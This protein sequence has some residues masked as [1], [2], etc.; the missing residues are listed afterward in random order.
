MEPHQQKKIILRQGKLL[1]FTPNDLMRRTVRMRDWRSS[2]LLQCLSLS[3]M[4]RSSLGL[5]LPKRRLRRL[6][7]A[8]EAAQE[9]IQFLAVVAIRCRRETIQRLRQLRN[10]RH[11]SLARLFCQQT[12]PPMRCDRWLRVDADL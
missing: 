8:Q 6:S 9:E 2:N 4:N 3:T 11:V 7:V 12:D 10:F 1:V 5:M